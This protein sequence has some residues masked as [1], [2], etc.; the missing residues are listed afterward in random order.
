MK[1]VN[2]KHPTVTDLTLIRNA[3]QLY[4]SIMLVLPFILKEF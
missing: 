2:P 1:Q 3:E 4:A